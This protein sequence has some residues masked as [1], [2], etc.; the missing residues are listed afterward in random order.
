[1]TLIPT[2]SSKDQS[3][4]CSGTTVPFLADWNGYAV[5]KVSTMGLDA[6]RSMRPATK[7]S[8]SGARCERVLLANLKSWEQGSV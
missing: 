8:F 5:T 6:C 7:E 2:R 1:M 3:A 4:K